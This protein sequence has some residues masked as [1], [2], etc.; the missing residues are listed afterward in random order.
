MVSKQTKAVAHLKASP[1]QELVAVFIRL[2]VLQLLQNTCRIMTSV[3]RLYGCPCRLILILLG[4][5]ACLTDGAADCSHDDRDRS[6]ATVDTD[7]FI[8]VY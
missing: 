5:V 7:A 1:C 6:I 3:V 2:F 4:T 8:I